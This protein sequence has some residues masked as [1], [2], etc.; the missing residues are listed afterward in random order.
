VKIGR[1]KVGLSQDALSN[2][3]DSTA[4]RTRFVKLTLSPE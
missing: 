2:I 3:V 1:Q 4:I